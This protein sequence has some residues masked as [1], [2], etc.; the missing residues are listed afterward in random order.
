M[1]R[2]RPMPRFDLSTKLDA[3]GGDCCDDGHADADADGDDFFR[4]DF[5]IIV[6]SIVDDSE[7]ITSGF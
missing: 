5:Q 7:A 4:D 1:P 6:V 3:S 2:H